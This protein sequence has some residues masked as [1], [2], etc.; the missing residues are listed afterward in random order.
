MSGGRF[1]YIQFRITDPVQSL[2]DA[3]RDRDYPDDIKADMEEC[4]HMLEV[5]STRLHRIDYLL[6]DDYGVDSYRRAVEKDKDG[7]L[8]TIPVCPECPP[9]VRRSGRVARPRLNISDTNYHGCGVDI[10]TCP[11]CGKT[12][13]IS[14]KIDKIERIRQD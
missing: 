12:F 1:D 6:S 9:D 2:R 8:D 4:A 7:F 10:A 3:A 13:T 14:Y 11:D 5:A